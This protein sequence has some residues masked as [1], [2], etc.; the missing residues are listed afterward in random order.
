V[1]NRPIGESSPNLVTLIVC[2]VNLW[3][4]QKWYQIREFA[5]L[6]WQ[7]LSLQDKLH[8]FF[9]KACRLSF[10]RLQLLH[11]HFSASFDSKHLFLAKCWGWLNKF[12][13][14]VWCSEPGWLDLDEFS[15]SLVCFFKYRR[16]PNFGRKKL[17]IN[18]DKKGCATF[19]AIFSHIHLWS[20]CSEH[21]FRRS[22][23]CSND[24]CSN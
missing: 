6:S 2:A 4:Q 24:Y 11:F 3:A 1:N 20:P 19:W 8:H 17:C 12:L 7:S 18:M 23:F 22:W 9:S 14:Y 21:S 15:P 5:K 10:F 13:Q 16:S